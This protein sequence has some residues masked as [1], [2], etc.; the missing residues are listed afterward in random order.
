MALRLS[1]L[2]DLAVGG[3]FTQVKHAAG[4]AFGAWNAAAIDDA[5][6]R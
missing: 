6:I 2:R 5:D 4:L 1:G 3:S